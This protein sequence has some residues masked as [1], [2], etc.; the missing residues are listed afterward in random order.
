MINKRLLIL[1][2]INAILA[3]V[4]LYSEHIPLFE[5]DGKNWSLNAIA[6]L[7]IQNNNLSLQA[8]DIALEKGDIQYIEHMFRERVEQNNYTL[9][10]KNNS[11]N[12]IS[13]LAAKVMLYIFLLNL[14]YLFW[15]K[16]KYNKA[17]KQD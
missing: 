4:I 12:S 13:N 16:M 7:D 8:L 6:E 2:L 14:F 17:L 10:L 11:K 5:R 3:S 1:A 15:D 9:E